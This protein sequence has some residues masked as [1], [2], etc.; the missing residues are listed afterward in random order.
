MNAAVDTSPRNFKPNFKVNLPTGIVSKLSWW[1]SGWLRYPVSFIG[2]S[3]A[4]KTLIG[5]SFYSSRDGAQAFPS[6]GLVTQLHSMKRRET[7]K[8]ILHAAKEE[9]RSKRIE[10]L[11][12]MRMPND[13]TMRLLFWP[14]ERLLAGDNTSRQF[15]Q[16]EEISRRGTIVVVLNPFSLTDTLAELALL[17]HISY[18]QRQHHFSFRDA[19]LIGART[20][21]SLSEQRVIDLL[22]PGG[23]DHS[24]KPTSIEEY[25]NSKVDLG[26][27]TIAWNPQNSGKHVP[28]FDY[29][30]CTKAE[31]ATIAEEIIGRL[32]R[33]HVADQLPEVKLIASWIKKETARHFLLVFT[34]HDIVPEI[35]GLD[36]QDLKTSCTDW[37]RKSELPLPLD[38]I[39][40][41]GLLSSKSRYPTLG[42]P[43]ARREADIDEGVANQ[44]AGWLISRVMD[45]LGR[46]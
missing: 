21:F 26:K 24:A 17:G 14:S 42:S 40:D 16:L 6:K 23:T 30:N 39:A 32:A 22:A 34:H 37:V 13:K 5:L 12:K 20:L 11:D 4:G 15:A 7:E 25:L 38:R 10:Y 8:S 33:R 46:R 41:V 29:L 2:P 18:L 36:A 3:A 28:A 9:A 27:I 19:L 1:Y 44:L 31:G 43:R 35:D 45:R